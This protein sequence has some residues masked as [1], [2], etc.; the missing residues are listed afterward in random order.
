MKNLDVMILSAKVSDLQMC[1]TGQAQ[2]SSNSVIEL[3]DKITIFEI[4]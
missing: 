2:T 4:K 1:V 3:G